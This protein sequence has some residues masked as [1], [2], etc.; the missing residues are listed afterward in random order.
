MASPSPDAAAKI[1]SEVTDWTPSDAAI[2]AGLNRPSIANP[3][4][5]PVVPTPFTTSQVFGAV[6]PSSLAKLNSI[7]FLPDIRDKIAANDRPACG[8]Y[9]GLLMAGGVITQPDYGAIMAI[10][11]ATGPD[12]AWP[13]QISWAVAHLGRPVDPSDIAA[14]RPGA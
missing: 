6:A 11:N 10:F 2:A 14:S 9:A 8:L 7:A 4:P 1:R 5:Q 12:P 13:A 3:T